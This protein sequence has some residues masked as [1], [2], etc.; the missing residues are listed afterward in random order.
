M[1]FIQFFLNLSF[2]SLEL[3]GDVFKLNELPLKVFYRVILLTSYAHYYRS[4]QNEDCSV[5]PVRIQNELVK[6]Y[7]LMQSYEKFPQFEVNIVM[8]P[9]QHRKALIRYV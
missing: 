5:G 6:W 2:R 7:G 9:F 1:I 8:S 3:L 4:N